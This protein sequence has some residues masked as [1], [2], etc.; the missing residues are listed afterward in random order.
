MLNRGIDPVGQISRHRDR[1][2]VGQG[3][4]QPAP[5]LAAL[6]AVLDVPGHRALATGRMGIQPVVNQLF[7]IAAVHDPPSALRLALSK[8][9]NRRRPRCRYV[10][11][12][13]TGT[14]SNSAMSVYGI[15]WK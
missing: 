15:S 4:Q 6:A 1:C 9:R 11:T 13:P 2:P 8:S 12:V 14:S 3:L 7:Y 5:A 10:R